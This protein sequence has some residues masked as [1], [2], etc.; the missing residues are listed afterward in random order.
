MSGAVFITGASAGIGAACAR[1]FAREGRDLILVARRLDRLEQLKQELGGQVRVDVF[2]LDVTD[3]QAVIDLVQSQAEVFER[4]EILLNNAG[5]ALGREPLHAGNPEDW[6][7]MLDLNVK[8]FLYVLHAVLPILIRR[9]TG[10][11]VNLSSA[12]GHYMYPNGNVYAASKFAVK[13]LTEGLRM[14]LH[15]KAIR[16]T[17]ISPGMVETEFSVVRFGDEEKAKAI[18]QGFTPLDPEDVADAVLWAV[19]R[20]PHVNIA[21]ILMFPTAQ[22][23]IDAVHRGS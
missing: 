14:D 5:M 10:H 12:A 20:P 9:G 17:S 21:D 16:V 13:G 6:D 3:R 22:S 8:G 23:R 15:G 19:T 18:Y 11:V 2:P 1:A 7:R 4:T